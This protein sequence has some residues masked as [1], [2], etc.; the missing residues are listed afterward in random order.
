MEPASSESAMTAD[1][2]RDMIH[3]VFPI[4]SAPAATEALHKT[5]VEVTHGNACGSTAPT[6][7]QHLQL[8]HGRSEPLQHG[9]APCTGSVGAQ[10]SR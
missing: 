1:D 3:K 8:R 9:P 4:T 6:G 7:R 5:F 10:T 2:L